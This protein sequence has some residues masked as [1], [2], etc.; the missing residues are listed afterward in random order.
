MNVKRHNVSAQL[1]GKCTHTPAPDRTFSEEPGKEKERRRKL[2]ELEK[3]APS[4]LTLTHIS[5]L[6]DSYYHNYYYI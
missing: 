6:V 3:R 4:P 2:E 1:Y 5:S